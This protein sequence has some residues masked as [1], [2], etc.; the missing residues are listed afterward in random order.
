[1]RALGWEA[2]DIKAGMLA[3]FVTIARID[4]RQ[5][6]PAQVVFSRSACDVTNVVVGGK[7]VV[8]Q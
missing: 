1:M 3:D 7:T 8:M 4:G 5:L 2:G 6:D